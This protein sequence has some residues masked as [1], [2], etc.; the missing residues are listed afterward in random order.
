MGGL[1]TPSFSTPIFTDETTRRCVDAVRK[2]AEQAGRD[3]GAI[4]VWACLATIGDHI[5]EPVRLQKTVGR[6]ATYLQAYGDLMVHTNGWD[7]EVLARFRKDS[8][9]AGFR[10]A[11][12]GAATTTELEHVATLLPEEWLDPSASGSPVEC[13]EAVRRQFDL[14]CDGVIMH[15]AAP[16]DLSPV[17]AAYRAGRDSG[18]FADLPAN[19]G[20]SRLEL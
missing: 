10:G 1:S 13:A 15:G 14:G 19:P 17:V 20:G 11:L 3:P 7:P 9:V 18:T 5:P 4:R 8:F 16:N 6:L 12:D 2:G